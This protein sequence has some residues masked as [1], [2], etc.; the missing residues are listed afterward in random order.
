MVF[1]TFLIF[2]GV[3]LSKEV[4]SFV[5]SDDIISNVR[6]D[7]LDVEAEVYFKGNLFINDDFSSIDKYTHR[8]DSNKTISDANSPLEAFNNYAGILSFK[9][10]FNLYDNIQFDIPI[11][12]DYISSYNLAAKK[13]LGIDML[14]DRVINNR[15]GL[16]LEWS[17][18]PKLKLGLKGGLDESAGYIFSL[19]NKLYADSNGDQ[20]GFDITNWKMVLF[21]EWHTVEGERASLTPTLKLAVARGYSAFEKSIDTDVVVD[22]TLYLPF[23]FDIDVSSSFSFNNLISLSLNYAFMGDS[24]VDDNISFYAKGSGLHLVLSNSSKFICNLPHGVQ[25]TVPLAGSFDGRFFSEVEVP[26]PS[27]KLSLSPQIEAE[28]TT[29][30]NVELV[31]KANL[32]WN[33]YKLTISDSLESSFN[34]KPTFIWSL[35]FKY[36]SY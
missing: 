16:W 33:F 36:N 28:I 9:F 35:G 21:S 10:K 12:F 20:R 14:L 22:T 4:D 11:S 26:T 30:K 31:L 32:K 15:V 13:R 24:H 18:L 8:T 3:A 7:I 2:F 25:V 27:L 29:W 34:T 6:E 23:E 17:A 19:K 5:Y 1:A